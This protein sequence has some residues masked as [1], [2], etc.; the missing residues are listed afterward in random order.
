[1]PSADTS[2]LSS[3]ARAYLRAAIRRTA[4][5]LALVLAAACASPGQAS[6]PGAL[7]D[8]QPTTIHGTVVNS[9][10]NAP[11]SRALVYS[12]DN[13]YAMLTDGEGHF[14]FTLPK[15]GNEGGSTYIAGQP[16]QMWP[17]E[18]RR[19]SFG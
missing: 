10:T 9:I 7:A 17:G 13:R 1:M 12:P 16:R 8:A 11:I 4:V 6:G 15:E 14:E 18:A 2:T 5:L 3:P 19:A